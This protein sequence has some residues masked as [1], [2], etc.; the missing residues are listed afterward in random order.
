MICKF[1]KHFDSLLTTT[2]V[3][4]HRSF[5]VNIYFV[6]SYSKTGGGFVTLLNESEVEVNVIYKELLMKAIGYRFL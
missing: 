2:I 5:I 4:I 1:L 3:R 6:K